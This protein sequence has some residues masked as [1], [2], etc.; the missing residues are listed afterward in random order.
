MVEVEH[1][2]FGLV[3]LFGR[4]ITIKAIL[5]QRDDLFAIF[6]ILADDQTSNFLTNRRLKKKMA[7]ILWEGQRREVAVIPFRWQ[8]RH[9][10]RS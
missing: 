8:F 9:P 2:L 10:L 5:R 6:H 3:T 7:D 4:Q 1:A